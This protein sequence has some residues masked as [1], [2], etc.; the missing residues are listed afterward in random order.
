[1]IADEVNNNRFNRIKQIRYE[2]DGLIEKKTEII[3][4]DGSDDVYIKIFKRAKKQID[5]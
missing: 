3:G 1:M 2:I 4:N 5:E